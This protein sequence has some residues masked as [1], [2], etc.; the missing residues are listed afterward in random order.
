MSDFESH[1]SLISH[2]RTVRDLLPLHST[3]GMISLLGGMPNPSTFPIKSLSLTSQSPSGEE[4]VLSLENDELREA[5]QYNM[6]Q[7]VPALVEWLFT[8]QERV[9]KR[10]RTEGWSVALGVGSAD[11]LYKVC[12]PLSFP[13]VRIDIMG[14]SV[15]ALFDAGDSILIESPGYPSVKQPFP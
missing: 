12:S 9:H 8:L 5:L 6:M 14:Q 15:T 13:P 10:H 11:L 1:F 2:L 7:G 4:V 3:P